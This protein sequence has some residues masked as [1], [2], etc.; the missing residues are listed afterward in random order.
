MHYQVVSFNYKK[1]TLPEREEIAFTSDGEIREFLDTLMAFEFMLEAFV[2]NT[3]NRVEIVS[4]SKDNFATFHAILGILSQRTGVGFH[5]LARRAMRFE[6]EEAVRHLFSVV[7]SLDSLVV[8]EAQITGQVKQGFRLS[9]ENRTA[10]KELNRLVS[11]A[12]K[13]AAEV[14]NATN[15]SENPVS[16][17]SVA[18][19]QA[20]ELMGGTLE[21]MTGLVVGTGEMGRLA[22]KHLLRSGADVLLVSRDPSKAQQIA[23]ELGENV[24]T[25]SFENLERYINR[26]RLLFSAT[27]SPDPIILPEMIE[28]KEINR[29]WFDMAIPR[30]IAD[31]SDPAIRVFRIDDLQ[32]ISKTNH[33]LRREQALRAAEIVDRRVEEFFRWLQAL[34]V[35]P[36]IKRMRLRVDD[37]ASAEARRAV[38]KGFIPAEYEANLRYA[39][40]QA[41]DKYLHDPTRNLRAI[42]KESDGSGVIEAMK[43]VF[44]I[45]TADVDPDRYK[46]QRKETKQ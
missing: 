30:D 44:E 26:Y 6:D 22:A 32:E 46:V 35:E 18:V 16:V 25:G 15:I 10:G 33:A 45:D 13:C 2:I 1:C 3:C 43:R 20:V 24:R 29:I 17:A 28:A 41:F 37:V 34:S 8:G 21:G 38:K 40:A 11:Q 39:I 19:A 27:S 4:A 9:Y 36:V 12:V 23:A 31:I 14:R 7:S 42:S 5:D